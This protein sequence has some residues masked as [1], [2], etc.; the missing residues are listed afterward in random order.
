MSELLE[1]TLLTGEGEG[2]PPRAV[3]LSVCGGPGGLRGPRVGG[4][5]RGRVTRLQPELHSSPRVPG[6]YY[7][8]SLSASL[9]LLSGLDQAHMLPLSPS[10]ELQRSLSLLE[11]RRLP[12][13]HSF[14]V[15]GPPRCPPP[16]TAKPPG[17]GVWGVGVGQGC[18]L[19][20]APSCAVPS[21]SQ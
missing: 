18:L 20:L 15:T 5:G 4:G 19:V 9:A 11:Q 3:C 8:T 2:A 13:T 7:L 12:A 17:G 16:P 21:F 10:Q 14:Q 1:P 6:G